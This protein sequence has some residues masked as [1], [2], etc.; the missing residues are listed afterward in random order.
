M[1]YKEG[2]EIEIVYN[3]GWFWDRLK[4][5]DRG[6]VNYV[7]NRGG[8]GILV[9]YDGGEVG[10]GVGAHKIH[11]IRKVN[12]EIRKSGFAR[13]IQRVDTNAA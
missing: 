13:F 6:V 8:C 7:D 11:L 9:K 4:A 1:E 10:Q 3:D 2:D 5:G 12:R